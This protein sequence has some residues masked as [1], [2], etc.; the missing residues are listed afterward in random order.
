MAKD[1]LLP[2]C[3]I[4]RV[5]QQRTDSLE[6]QLQVKRTFMPIQRRVYPL[7]L[8]HGISASIGQRGF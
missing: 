6:R 7:L 5:R 8:S 1:S 3:A 4:C 2:E